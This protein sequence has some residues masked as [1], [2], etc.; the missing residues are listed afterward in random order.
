MTSRA[1][2][3]KEL[4]KKSSKKDNRSD[5]C[6]QIEFVNHQKSYYKRQYADLIWHMSGANA[7][8][9]EIRNSVS[10]DAKHFISWE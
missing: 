8:V 1:D 2:K 3:L 9:N 10:V 5:I 4:P 7:I 6:R